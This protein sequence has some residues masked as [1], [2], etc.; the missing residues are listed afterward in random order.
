MAPGLDLFDTQG[1]LQRDSALVGQALEV[2]RD[3]ED[4]GSEPTGAALL[5]A[6][7]AQGFKGFSRAPFGWPS[8]LI[9]LV[10]AA[11]FRAGAIYLE[12][13]SGAGPASIYDYSGSEDYFGKVNTFKKISLRVAETSLSVEQ[14]KQAS[15]TL[16]GPWR[17]R[18]SR[19]GQR[20][21]ERSPQTRRD[22]E[23]QAR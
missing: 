12:R 3:M 7:D 22:P 19:V 13:Q 9:R 21:R 10:L 6:R 18:R 8:E 23:G 1:S 14:I 11:C 20:H 4:E 15:K 16:I 17:E 5:D 2:L